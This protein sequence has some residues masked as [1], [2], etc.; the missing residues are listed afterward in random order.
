MIT[1][2]RNCKT[3]LTPQQTSIDYK[4]GGDGVETGML[5]G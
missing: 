3:I 5:Q 2:D 4:N 1:I